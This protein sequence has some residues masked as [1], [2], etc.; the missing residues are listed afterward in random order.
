VVLPRAYLLHA[1]RGYQSIP[2]LPCAS[3]F[4]GEVERK[5]SSGACGRE[6]AQPC[7]LFEAWI[8]LAATMSWAGVAQGR[9]N[10]ADVLLDPE[11]SFDDR[12]RLGVEHSCVRVWKISYSTRHVPDQASVISAVRRGAD[13]R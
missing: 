1:D 7:L 12:H 11:S 8:K 2:G 10:I 4:R 9:Q 5:Q 6:T 3:S 13:L